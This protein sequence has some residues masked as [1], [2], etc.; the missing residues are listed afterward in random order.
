MSNKSKLGIFGGMA[1]F[2]IAATLILFNP[3]PTVADS[4]LPVVTVYKSPTCG[5]CGKWVKH[6]ESSGFKVISKNRK[7]LDPIKKQFAI[8]QSFQSC[9]TAKIG[10]Y[11]VEG[12]VP[13]DDIKRM[14]KEKPAIDGLAVPGMPMGSPGMEGHRKDNY[15]VLVINKG[16]VTGVFSK[17]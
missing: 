6:M 13:A 14:L 5:C 16:D 12:H 4:H 9:H 1:A 7:N 2:A 10:D 11:V 15:E 17:H 8:K 3:K